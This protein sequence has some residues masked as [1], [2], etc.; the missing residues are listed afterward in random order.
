M[1]KT[2]RITGVIAVLMAMAVFALPIKYGI[3]T[4]Q[5]VE[6]FINGPMV[7]DVFKAAL[8]SRPVTP[9]NQVH[10]LIQQAEAFALI[11][12]PPKPIAQTPTQTGPKGG[13]KPPVVVTP[14]VTPK[15]NLISTIYYPFNPEMSQALIEEGKVRRWV[16]QSSEVNHLLI[17]EVKDGIILV[18]NGDEVT[19]MKTPEKKFTGSVPI[20]PAMGRITSPPS[21]GGSPVIST[22]S[23]GNSVR[24]PRTPT[25]VSS[26]TTVAPKTE[27]D[28][29]TK[30]GVEELMEKIKILENEGS[31]DGVPLT[32]EEKAVE[33]QKLLGELRN[34]NMNIS[35]EESQKLNN[36]EDLIENTQDTSVEK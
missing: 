8:S 6:N 36:L 13:V 33:I 32:M 17:E 15:F 16:K 12:N 26:K 27:P 7:T 23:G 34:A 35:D 10:P 18:R 29:G 22:P 25:A 19:E 2:L 28:E 3:K 5:N 24:P 14:Q 1:I 20:L 31:S 21:K 4:D 11:L 9:S 30:A